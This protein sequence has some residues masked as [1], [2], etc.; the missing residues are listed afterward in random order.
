MLP[1]FFVI[2]AAKAGT[3][4]I[5]EFLR[6]HPEVFMPEGFKESNHFLLNGARADFQGPGD[7][8]LNQLAVHDRADYVRL[9]D[10]AE[11]QIAVGEVCPFYMAST[12]IPGRIRSFAP[13]AKIV[14]ILRN[15]ADRAFSSYLHLVRDRR[16]DLDFA[17]SLRREAERAAQNWEPLWRYRDLGLY[18]KY[19]SVY[20]DQFDA[21]RIR[22]YLFEELTRGNRAT[23]ADLM[24]F[25]G[26]DDSVNIELAKVN[27]AAHATLSRTRTIE[28]LV[29]REN[30]VKRV[31]KRILPE[32]SIRKARNLLLNANRYSPRFDPAVRRELQDFYRPD[33]E[34]LE[35]LIDRDLGH[36]LVT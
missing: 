16:E 32:E 7:Y 18:H 14:A 23:L 24:Q 10:E 36:W 26:I 9:F 4:S 30:V 6:H 33:I 5:W 12:E 1:N 13:E 27:S 21:S 25:L 34:R 8:W 11:G 31:A 15:P 20:F 28:D 2:G 3:T 19:L 35:K 29:F 17:S 22:I